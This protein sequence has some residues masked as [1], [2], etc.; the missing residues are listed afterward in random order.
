MRSFLVDKGEQKVTLIPQDNPASLMR[1]RV[2]EDNIERFLCKRGFGCEH[3]TDLDLDVPEVAERY[4]AILTSMVLNCR[5]CKLAVETPYSHCAPIYVRNPV[6]V[7]VGRSPSKSEALKNQIVDMETPCGR[8]FDKYLEKLGLSRADVAVLNAVQCHTKGNRPPES[9]C[10]KKCLA[11]KRLEFYYINRFKI[12]FLMGNDAVYWLYG[13]NHPGVLKV[14]G[15]VYSTLLRSD[16][17]DLGFE[18]EV[19]VIPVVH[20]NHL[21]INPELGESVSNIL[22]LASQILKQID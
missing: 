13:R 4:K 7:C 8:V 2:V 5:S 22:N 9:E 12:L 11:Y 14:Q 16:S 1:H 15:M 21:V 3:I 17:L 18:Q 20:P 6:A 19:I 10:V